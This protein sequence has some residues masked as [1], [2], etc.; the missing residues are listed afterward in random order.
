MAELQGRGHRVRGF[1]RVPTPGVPEALVGDLTDAA[2]VQNAVA[3]AGTVI[4]L[5][6]AP[7]DD[8][9]FSQL[10]PNN[11]VGLYHVM[12][13]ARAAGVRRVVLPS[14]GQVN[15]WRNL[16]GPWPIH[17]DDPVTPRY[18]YAATKMF[19]EAIGRSYVE[20]HGLSVIVARLGWCPRTLAQVAEI[21]ASEWAQDIYLSP[22]DAGRFFASCVETAD[23][24]FAILY[25]A[26]RALNTVR[27]DLGPTKRTLGWEPHESWP[28][29]VEV[30][31]K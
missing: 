28:Q 8:D 1:D 9:F 20:M 5:A 18:W 16:Q 24:R 4:H 22:G 23:V 29:G 15:W 11:I 3:G 21:S 27:F 25:A 2:A 19:M 7:D 12:E 14:S 26:S 31:T 13:A 17:P 10:L 6:A 30:V